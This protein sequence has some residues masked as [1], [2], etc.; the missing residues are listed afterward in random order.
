MRFEQRSNEIRDL[1]QKDRMKVALQIKTVSILNDNKV[2]G[3]GDDKNGSLSSKVPKLRDLANLEEA[4]SL[5]KDNSFDLKAKTSLNVWKFKADQS[6]LCSL[7]DLETKIYQYINLK[8]IDESVGWITALI[9]SASKVKSAVKREGNYAVLFLIFG[10]GCYT[11]TL[12]LFVLFCIWCLKGAP[13]RF[14]IFG[15]IAL[16]VISKVDN[17]VKGLVS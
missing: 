13:Q 5:L 9:Q 4:V 7:A 10:I 6:E 11:V 12:L 8:K 15:I 14:L 3:K 17:S 2:N 16:L 1:I